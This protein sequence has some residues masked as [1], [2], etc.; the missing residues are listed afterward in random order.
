MISNQ[1]K[2]NKILYI[3]QIKISA[4]I[5]FNCETILRLIKEFYSVEFRFISLVVFYTSRK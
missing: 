3:F 2:I 1:I 5:F 4:K